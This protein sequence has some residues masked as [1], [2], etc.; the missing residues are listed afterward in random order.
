MARMFW[1]ETETGSQPHFLSIVFINKGTQNLIEE[2]VNISYDCY[3]KQ[4]RPFNVSV[5]C[6]N[7]VWSNQTGCYKHFRK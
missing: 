3:F 6:S 5:P 4:R 2:G 7:K 1:L